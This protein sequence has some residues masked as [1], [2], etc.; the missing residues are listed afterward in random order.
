M[1]SLVIYCQFLIA[2]SSLYL[3]EE[4]SVVSIIAAGHVF[5]T[6]CRLSC[7][8]LVLPY[9]E[10]QMLH[11]CQPCFVSVDKRGLRHGQLLLLV[12]NSAGRATLNAGF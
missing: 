5:E 9:F 3:F 7:C 12:N 11:D 2:C 6:S 10:K 4:W 1:P 8:A